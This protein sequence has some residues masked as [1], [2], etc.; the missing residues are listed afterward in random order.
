[1][2]IEKG[3]TGGI[4]ARWAPE[5]RMPGWLGVALVVAMVIL[6]GGVGALVMTQV[7]GRSLQVQIPGITVPA[8]ADTITVIGQGRVAAVPDTIYTDIGAE[9]IR[10][11]LPQALA[12][13][14]DDATKLTAA[15]KSA[16]VADVDMQTTSLYAYQRTD[17]Y[18]NVTGFSAST[19]LRVRIR[20]VTKATAVINAAAN[21]IGNDVRLGQFQY[22]R[23]DITV[24]AAQARQLALTA[25]Q[26]RA[27][28]IAK[29]SNRSLGKISSVTEDFAGY[30]PAGQM[31][32]GIGGGGGMGGGGSVP[33]VYSGQG[34]VV[35]NLYVSYSLGS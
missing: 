14:G 28:G 18:G 19:N 26:D 25:A 15:L 29:L 17:Q 22:Q 1:M 32:Q 13:T 7:S 34:E 21:A 31:M 6:A 8:A 27:A 4:P 33:Q 11:N 9:T 3:R 5:W 10:P 2:A 12:A 30:V 20:D 35:V 23:T 16:G 24:Q